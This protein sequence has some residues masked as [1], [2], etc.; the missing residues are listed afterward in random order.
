MFLYQQA[1]AMRWKDFEEATEIRSVIGEEFCSLFAQIKQ[2][3]NQ[4]YQRE[5]SPWERQHLLLNV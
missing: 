3:E 1:C 5:I 2:A 4:E